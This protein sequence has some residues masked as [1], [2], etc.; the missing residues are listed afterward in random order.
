MHVTNLTSRVALELDTA[1]LDVSSEYGH[2]SSGIEHQQ[3]GF[4]RTWRDEHRGRTDDSRTLTD[5]DTR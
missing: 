2:D 4:R 3:R 1:P 5:A